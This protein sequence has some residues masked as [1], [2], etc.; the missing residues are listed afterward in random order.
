MLF[1]GILIPVFTL[2]VIFLFGIQKF[3][4]QVRQVAGDRFRQ[5]L[6]RFTKTPTRGMAAGA[7]FT[8][9][10]QSSTATTVILVGL[11]DAGLV[12]FSH[13]LGVIIGANIGTT[14]TSQLVA[15]KITNIAPLFVLLG[16]FIT[17]F[18]R[19]YR[20]WGKPIF[21]FGLVF[22]SLSLISLYIEPVKSD[23][24]F[25][26][27]FAGISN[28]YLAIAVGILFTI[29]VQ[30]SSVISGL[31]VLL[32]AAGLLELEPAIGVILGANIGTTATALIA[33]LTLGANARKAAMAHFIFNIAGVIIVLPFITPFTR[34]VA[35]LGG[36]PEQVVANAHLIFNLA[37]AILVLPFLKHLETII[38]L[39]ISANRR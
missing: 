27:F 21:Y 38:S 14:I 36:S 31:V 4:K 35:S 2:V 22:F 3:S 17:Y 29:I 28:I 5:I 13:S 23:P 33:S 37:S 16:F 24:A 39:L 34:F 25:V 11:V 15:F 30:S 19:S 26:A 6:V 7:I 9:L 18:G 10:I 32:V 12:S 8:A 1:T 20:H